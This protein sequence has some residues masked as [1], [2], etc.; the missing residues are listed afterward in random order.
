[1]YV[2]PAYK[3]QSI[4]GADEREVQPLFAN[5]SKQCNYFFDIGA[6]DGYCSLF[7][8]K[9]NPSGEVYLFDADA[10]FQD[11]QKAHFDLNDIAKVF[12]HLQG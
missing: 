12:N 6:S 11:I 9:Y 5:Y 7:Y 8:K 10:K 1:M 3:F 4:I 2:D